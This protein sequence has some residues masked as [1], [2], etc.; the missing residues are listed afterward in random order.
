MLRLGVHAGLIVL[1]TL[2]TQVGGAVYGLALW[3]RPRFAW[4]ATSL[5]FA[6][7]FV[8]LYAVTWFPIGQLAA[9]GGRKPLPCIERAGLSASLV[10][11]ALHR[12][13]VAPQLFDVIASLS[14][15]VAQRYPGG[16]TRALDAS[17]P[18]FDDVPLPPHLSHDDGEKVDLAFHYT[19]GGEPAPGAL[20]SPIGYWRFEQP[21]EGEPLPCGTRSQG[22]RW[23]M[24]W[25]A[26]FTSRDLVLDDE[27]TRHV[28]RW[29]AST[30][31]QRGVGKVFVEPHLAERLN[32]SGDV[33]R[34]QGCRVARHDDHIH[35]QLR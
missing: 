31:A 29:L 33:I 30:G 25:F 6:S 15:D 22:W 26:P 14:A 4:A 3:L 20:A 2:L 9:L 34:F 7:L 21:R 16:K 18:F 27:R 11:C 19:R 35:V 24:E 8:A 12:N 32:A 1:L 13:Y 17:F 10:S 28:L 5:G 23:N